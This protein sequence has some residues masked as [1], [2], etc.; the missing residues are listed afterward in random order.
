MLPTQFASG[1]DV[2]CPSEEVHR[3]LDLLVD[4]LVCALPF[5]EVEVALPA[6]RGRAVK[7]HIRQRVYVKLAPCAGE[8][9]NRTVSMSIEL[10]QTM[11]TSASVQ[12][13]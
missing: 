8:L 9:K 12:T 11:R 3:V 1:F 13:S 5:L 7:V 4:C 2:P 10:C 6:S